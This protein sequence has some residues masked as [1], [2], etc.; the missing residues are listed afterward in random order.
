MKNLYL[1]NYK[2]WRKIMAKYGDRTLQVHAGQENP[3]SAFGARAVPIYMTSSFV[4]KDADYAADLFAL[5]EPGHIYTRLNNPTNT[6]SLENNF[7]II[8]VDYR[9]GGEGLEFGDIYCS[10]SWCFGWSN[11]SWL[12]VH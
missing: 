8:L 12:H 11:I 10:F 4:F 2:I 9:Y 3:E 6:A 7:T 5:T 1:K